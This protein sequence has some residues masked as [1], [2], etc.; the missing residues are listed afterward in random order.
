MPYYEQLEK[1]FQ[2]KFSEETVFVV[3]EESELS[4]QFWHFSFSND[5]VLAE[6]Q[7]QDFGT[8]FSWWINRINSF[9]SMRI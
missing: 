1:G 3:F 9:N 5:L 7:I 6:H 8:I 2:Q 4:F